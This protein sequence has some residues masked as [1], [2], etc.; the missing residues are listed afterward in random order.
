MG[1]SII[2]RT[3]FG[4]LFSPP[5]AE[6]SPRLAFQRAKLS[7]PASKLRYSSTVLPAAGLYPMQVIRVAWKL[8]EGVPT[9][10]VDGCEVF[11]IFVVRHCIGF[12]LLIIDCLIKKESGKRMCARAVKATI[13]LPTVTCGKSR[14]IKKNFNSNPS[15]QSILSSYNKTKYGSPNHPPPYSV[16]DVQYLALAESLCALKGLREITP[17]TMHS[18]WDN[19]N[20]CDLAS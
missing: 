18:L 15:Q 13:D 2:Q 8:R 1:E 5:V 11:G 12:S 6:S 17:W 9:W 16:F 19:V 20:A 14:Q 4:P 3:T 10:G 7:S